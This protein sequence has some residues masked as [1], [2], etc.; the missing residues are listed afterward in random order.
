MK[1]GFYEKEITPPLGQSLPGYFCPR[2]AMD[3]WD[4]LYAKSAVFEGENGI[5]AVLILDAVQVKKAF[6]EKVAQRVTE[7][8]GIPADNLVI[9]ATHTHYGVPFGD[10]VP[11][12]C[13]YINEP[14]RE[15]VKVLE[16]LAAD[17]VILAWKRM[18][19]CTLSY[20]MGWEGH[21][22]F[23]RDYQMKDGKVRTNPSSRR[24]PDILHPYSDIDPD[25]PVLMVRNAEGQLKG[26]LFTHTCHQ[27]VVGHY[28]YSG[29]YSSVVSKELKSVY[30]SDFVSIYMA[31]CCGDINH[32]DPLGGARRSHVDVGRLVAGAVKAAMAVPGEPVEGQQVAALRRWVPIV[33]RK[34]TEEELAECRKAIAGEEAAFSRDWALSI[35]GYEANGWPDEVLQPAQILRIGE[36][37]LLAFPGEVYHVYGQQARAAIPGEKWLI[38]EL[39]GTESSYMPTPELFGTDIYPAKLTDGSFLE[40]RAG[41]KMVA[42][43]HEMIKEMK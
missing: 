23:C 7:Y 3:V 26:I 13:E 2:P 8:T 10:S 43:F 9:A 14:D 27:D 42:A 15:Y 12:D 36:L 41:E 33:R 38:T 39:S 25:T 37:W 29:D 17:T 21:A 20:S 24:I 31:G 28:V 22:S 4:K 6:C 16:R 35:V 32:C 40:P 34:A 19:E 30:G 1:C 5:V 18:E 11:D